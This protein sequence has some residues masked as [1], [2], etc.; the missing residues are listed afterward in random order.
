MKIVHVLNHFLQDKVG[1]TEVYVKELCKGLNTSNYT[2]EIIVPNSN[3]HIKTPFHS[4]KFN[5]SR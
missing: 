3:V 1:G 4:M 2:S 5:H